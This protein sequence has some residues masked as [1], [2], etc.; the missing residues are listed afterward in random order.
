MTALPDEPDFDL[1]GYRSG[2]NRCLRLAKHWY[3]LGGI[4]PSRARCGR[5]ELV[6]TAARSGPDDLRPLEVSRE[7]FLVSLVMDT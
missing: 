3:V 6:G 1:C 7:E 4:G 2:R 5:H